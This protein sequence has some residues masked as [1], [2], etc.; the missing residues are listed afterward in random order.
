MEGTTGLRHGARYSEDSS[1]LEP[2]F[3]IGSWNQIP[4]TTYSIYLSDEVQSQMEKRFKNPAVKLTE[5]VA[6]E[7]LKRAGVTLGPNLGIT[8]PKERKASGF[9]RGLVKRL[10]GG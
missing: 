1:H 5:A 8:P 2:A 10:A 3:R 6:A 4:K 7:R 9:S